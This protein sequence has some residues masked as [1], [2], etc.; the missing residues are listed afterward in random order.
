MRTLAAL[1]A[2]IY[3]SACATTS[4][5][6]MDGGPDPVKPG[7]DVTISMRDGSSHQF[8][9]ERISDDAVCGPVECLR[10]QEIASID[11]SR[12]DAPR[13]A[14]AVLLAVAV[15]ALVVGIAA[16]HSGGIGFPPGAFKP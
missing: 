2:C 8:R 6:A 1:V 9:V 7:D 4:N 3:L 14:G 13:T 16:L 12:I 10:K 15:V 11:R 5:V